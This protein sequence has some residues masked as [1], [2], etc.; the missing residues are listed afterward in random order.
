[1]SKKTRIAKRL[2]AS[3]LAVATIASGL[4]FGSVPAATAATN[5]DTRVSTSAPLV[6]SKDGKSFWAMTKQNGATHFVE[7]STRADAEANGRVL[8]LPTDESKWAKVSYWVEHAQYCLNVN[9][10]GLMFATGNCFTSASDFRLAA[11]GLVNRAYPELHVDGFQSYGSGPQAHFGT[12]TD[13]YRVTA[14]SGEVDSIDLHGRTAVVTGYANPGAQVI[15]KW[16]D[17]EEQTTAI[18]GGTWAY[19]IDGLELGSNPVRLE[20]W[21]GGEMTGEY[22]LDVDL[23]VAALTVAHRFGESVSDEV[24]LSGAAEPGAIIRVEDGAGKTVASSEPADAET[25]AW[26]L[27]L[28]APNKAGKYDLNVAQV[29]DG[30]ATSATDVS[31]DYGAQLVVTRPAGDVEFP[32]GRL[33]MAGNGEPGS[34][35]TVR[36]G[37]VL[38]GSTTVLGNGAW[39]LRTTDLSAQE[40]KLTVTQNSRGN[41]TTSEQVVV[42]PGASAV[43]AP[44]ATVEFGAKVTDRAMIA[45][46]GENGVSIT[47]RDA[48]NAVIGTPQVVDGKFSL[49]ITSPGAGQHDFFVTQTVGDETSEPVKVTGDFGAAVAV[50]PL[51]AQST[52]GDVAVS[53][54]GQDGATVTVK[55]GSQT[56]TV[57]VEDG[58]WSTTLEL[59]PSNTAANVSVSQTAQGNTVT[60]T[61][62]TT[63]PNASIAQAPV[64]IDQP[65][66]QAYTPMVN[67]TLSGSAT[68]YAQV[69]VET[70]QGGQI[71]TV[72]ADK[73][74]K[75]SFDRVYG[76]SA[77][78]TL[79]ATQTR[80]D[81][82]TSK[83]AEFV[84]NPVGAF[85]P[86][87]LTTHADGRYIPGENLFSGTAT[88]DATITAKNQW[89]AVLF[90]AKASSVSG[91]WAT[92]R[93]LGPSATYEMTITQVAPDGQKDQVSK[94][95]RPVEAA[96]VPAALTSP[97]NNSSYRPGNVTF[98]GTGTTGTQIVAKNQWGT[99][100]GAAT[101]GA[102]GK[103]SFDRNLGPSADYQITFTAKRGADTNTFTVNVNAPKSAPLV[104]TSPEVGATYEPLKN[105]TFTGTAIPFATID[106]QTKLGTKIA[107]TT[108]DANGQWRFTRAYGPTN[109]YQLVF[110]QSEASG[111]QH[112]TVEFTFGPNTTK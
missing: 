26:S 60:T 109:V 62:A 100:M 86:L 13:R 47:V 84:M 95:L 65:S 106:V 48:S 63:T 67:T 14:L 80:V 70:K 105:V 110:S 34:E 33:P 37:S 19:N 20:Q 108:A 79:I 57:T 21:E 50:T 98:T 25:G 27:Q 69:K 74:G 96:Y 72:T 31:V 42:N 59:A 71:R 103:W 18:A 4:S 99:Q 61:T 5:G 35:V 107:T 73:A 94:T 38:V 45:G 85:R 83:S 66:T 97:T 89:G 78:Y 49:P 39:N 29:I 23:K 111:T 87:A 76:P 104:I 43:P 90:T 68:P 17:N 10:A 91:A 28:A 6:L 52:P 22:T 2:G 88:P 54:A 40:H 12:G 58:R 32:G 82:S 41:N 51:P 75:W 53:G 11:G 30:E 8:D 102:D 81:G 55:L 46:T 15:V 93:N 101:V 64:T 92:K 16:G 24:T 77:V 3:A 36:E 7:Y 9:P 56:K 112:P 44:S 1:M